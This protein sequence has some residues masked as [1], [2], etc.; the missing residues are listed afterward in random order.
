[1]LTPSES[2]HLLFSIVCIHR[3]IYAY[4][5]ERENGIAKE[6]EALG[7]EF[8]LLVGE[9]A[10][11]I[12]H[13]VTSWEVATNAKPKARVLVVA[14][15]LGNVAKSVVAALRAILAHAE[16]AKRKGYIVRYNEEVFTR[17]TLL[18]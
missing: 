6:L 3:A 8:V 11:D 17:N 7:H 9:V 12:V 14:K 2:Q 18:L 16:G 1:M 15:H 10:K 5:N 4:R 13:L